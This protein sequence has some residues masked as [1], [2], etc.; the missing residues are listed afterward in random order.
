MKKRKYKKMWI[1]LAVVIFIMAGVAVFFRVPYSPTV[2]QF[3]NLTAEQ[4]ETAASAS[5]MFT[6]EDIRHLPLPVQR[7]FRYC[8]YLG[9]PKM[10]Y[11]KAS[12]SG[13]DFVMSETRTIKIDYKQFN[14]VERPNRYALISSSLYGIPFEGL[15][16]YANGTGS[17]KG[18]LG[19]IFRLF[20]QRGENMDRACL[21]T[22]LAECLMV[23]SAALQD[24]VKWETVDDT[25]AKASIS[26]K[27]ISASG[28]FSFAENGELLAFRTG[29]RVAID[30]DG[31]ET[32]AE[33]SA[34]FR[35][36][37][38]ANG[39]LQPTVIQSV[40][41][42]AEGDCVYFNQNEAIITIQYQ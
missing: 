16:A 9:T 42:Y 39:L 19:K 29:D 8:G 36:Y 21:V 18:T 10:A 12:L 30:M 40:W 33:W 1:T 28:V 37:H 23:P 20:D 15:D 27:G 38:S 14:L 35:K 6:E 25:H 11:M 2:S 34:F 17:M 5:G 3:Q 4:I 13:V 24:F 32:K 31:K 41:H 26:W 7:Y 22:W